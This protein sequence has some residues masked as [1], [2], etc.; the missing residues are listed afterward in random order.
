MSGLAAFISSCTTTGVDVAAWGPPRSAGKPSRT[1]TSNETVRTPERSRVERSI[2]SA[3][4]QSEAPVFANDASGRSSRQPPPPARQRSTA[5]A[6]PMSSLAETA[7]GNLTYGA[8]RRVFAAGR[9]TTTVGGVS[10]KLLSCP[11]RRGAAKPSSPTRSSVQDDTRLETIS[12]ASAGRPSTRSD[13][14]TARPPRSSAKETREPST[15]SMA[16][17]SSLETTLGERP[18]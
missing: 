8:R 10:R 14:F 9:S 18:V 6:T 13:A 4:F 12:W 17:T 11:P 7:S 3:P 15:A 16:D 5:P 1:T 2:S